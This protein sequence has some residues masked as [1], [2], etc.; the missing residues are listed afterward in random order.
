MGAATM[1]L[2]WIIAALL[3]SSLLVYLSARHTRRLLPEIELPP[4]ETLPRTPVQRAAGWSLAA[5]SVLSA[6]AA[7][8]VIWSGPAAW[9][10]TDAIRLTFTGL[11]LVALLAYL[12]FTLSVR[13]MAERDDGTFDERDQLILGRSSAGVGGAMMVTV[14]IWMIA[15]TES[16]NDTHLVPTYYL[17]LMFW[18]CVMMNVIASLAGV[19]LAYRKG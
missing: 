3:I 11:L 6:L 5:V 18:S 16:N 10:E 7:V 19:L 9:W 2:L 4:G 8:V 17:Y 15:L 12:G 14:A 13:R 1:M